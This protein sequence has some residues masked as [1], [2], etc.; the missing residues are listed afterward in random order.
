MKAKIL[1]IEGKRIDR[2]SFLIGLS[3]K[4]F[5]V[6]SVPNGAAALAR[7]EEELPH[8]VVVDAASMRTSGKRICGAI[9]ERHNQL[10]IVLV[11]DEKAE[12]VGKVDAQVVLRLP[13]TTQKLVNR[14]RGYLPLKQVDTLRVG[15]IELDTKH[16]MVYCGG[17]QTRLTPRLVALLKNMMHHPGE[18]ILREELFSKVWDTSYTADTRTLDVHISWLRQALEKDPR[19]PKLI[20]T[21]RDVGY[22]LDIEDPNKP[23]SE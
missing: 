12:E 10:P 22:R 7:L 13:F 3:K 5:L 6:E 11:L 19:H 23:K 4:G 20:K 17:K 2:P 1:L 9:H 14:M 15:P 16:R 8:V 21:M 18:V